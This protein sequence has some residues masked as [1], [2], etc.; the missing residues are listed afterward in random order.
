MS[1]KE[2]IEGVGG[3]GESRGNNDTLF[4]TIHPDTKQG[5]RKSHC[6]YTK[7]HYPAMN[8]I[9]GLLVDPGTYN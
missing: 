4:L 8:N 6:S 7:Y 2:T 3:G 9:N 5:T 1:V